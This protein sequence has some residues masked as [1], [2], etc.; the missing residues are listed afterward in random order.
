MEILV[1]EAN[2]FCDWYAKRELNKKDIK[3]F[4]RKFKDNS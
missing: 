1:R 2:L 3:I 4:K